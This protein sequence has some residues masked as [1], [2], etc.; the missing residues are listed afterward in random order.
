MD[1]PNDNQGKRWL[2][3]V[4]ATPALEIPND[5]AMWKQQRD[6]IRKQLQA[7]LGNLPP[8][9]SLPDVRMVSRREQPDYR[10]EKL[11]F[12]NAAGAKVPGYLLL[13]KSGPLPHPAIL[14]CHWHGGEYAIGKEEI[15]QRAHTPE[16]PGPALARRGYV[17]LAIDAYCFGERSGQGPGGPGEKG[18]TE[19]M[20]TSKFNLWYGRTLWGMMLRDDLMALDYLASR[21]EVDRSRMGVTGISMGATRAWWLMALDDRLRTGVAVA[22]LTRY[23]DLIAS[24]SLSAHGIYYFVPGLL[25]RFDTEAVLALIAPRPLL[26]MT[27]DQDHG[28]PVSGIRKIESAV[29]PAYRLFGREDQFQNK[30]FPGIGHVYT[31]EMWNAMLSWME[32]HLQSSSR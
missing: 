5:S 6:Q 16:E 18:G 10:V 22:C 21:P 19:E 2:K 14:Y 17:V 32:L 25:S 4:P 24:E 9:P 28:S 30:V 27:G 3:A 12:D 13:P 11:E 29:K 7:L 15:F 20:S 26:L 31:A 23:Q 1:E 8:R